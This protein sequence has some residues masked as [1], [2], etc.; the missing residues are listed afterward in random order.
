M[1]ILDLQQRARQIGRIRI[2]AQVK[3]SNGKMR[4]SKLDSFR[5]TTSSRQVADA[6][7]AAYGGTVAKWAGGT[8][9]YEVYTDATELEVMIP[10]GEVAVSQWYE[11]WSGGGC[12]RRCDG[13]IDTISGGDC[14]CPPPGPERVAAAAEGKACKPTTRVNVILP[15]LPDIGLWRY[16]S[17]GFYAATELGGAAEMLAKARESGVI[18]PAR[19]RLEQREV[20]RGGQTR[21]F[22]VV[23][24]EIGATLRQL[25]EGTT[26][27]TI[28]EALP[29]AP[30]SAITAV[31]ADQPEIR[32]IPAANAM[33]ATA[34][35]LIDRA[36]SATFDSEVI[37]LGQHA[38]SLGWMDDMVS[39]ADGVYDVLQSVLYQVLADVRRNAEAV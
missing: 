39:D 29:P 30:A 12:Q 13:L 10:A 19:L 33:P 8:Q 23:V 26:G 7:A 31:P 28:R 20:K 16:D 14:L 1:P 24:L 5:F 37:A 6:V 38:K 34:Q 9:D 3:A 18:V 15:D 32:A 27:G 21:K 22:A 4:P 36:R 11:M 2:G 35:E 17:G 25:A